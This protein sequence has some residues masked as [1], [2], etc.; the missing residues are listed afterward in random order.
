MDVHY[1]IDE[2][3]EEQALSTPA[4]YIKDDVDTV[5]CWLETRETMEN[6]AYRT[7]VTYTDNGIPSLFYKTTLRGISCHEIGTRNNELE[8]VSLSFEEPR[9]YG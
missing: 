3:S 8:Q 4:D 6:L 2:L 7:A 9:L 5:K 1:Y